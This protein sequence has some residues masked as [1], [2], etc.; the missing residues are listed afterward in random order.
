MF[1]NIKAE[2][3]RSGMSMTE[4]AKF[5]GVNRK[6]VYRWMRG[7][8]EIP[9]SMIVKMSSLFHCPTDYLLGI[10]DPKTA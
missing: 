3:G 2:L 7:S 6:T 1:P 4:L 5:L 8:A 10:D 9:A